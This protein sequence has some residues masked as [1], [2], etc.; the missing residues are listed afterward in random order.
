MHELPNGAICKSKEHTFIQHARFFN[1]SVEEG[2]YLGHYN[3]ISKDNY[4]VIKKIE[5]ERQLR[6]LDVKFMNNRYIKNIQDET[7]LEEHQYLLHKVI[8]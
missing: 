2:T 6:L 7:L 5:A 8:P 3:M 4:E 1:L